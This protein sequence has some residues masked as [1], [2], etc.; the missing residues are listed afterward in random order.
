[1]STRFPDL[2]ILSREEVERSQTA[3]RLSQTEKYGGLFYLG[4]GGLAV[5][6][7][8]VSWFGWSVWSMR[9]VW[10][11]VYELTDPQRPENERIEAANRLASDP[12]A[13]PRQLW[14]LSLNRSVPPLARYT[15]AATLDER[16]LEPDATAYAL[17]IAR[18]EGWPDWLRLALVRPL[19][20][21]A[22]Q[23]PLPQAP[24][25]ELRAHPSL[26][27]QAWAAYAQAVSRKDEEAGKALSELATIPGPAGSVAQALVTALQAPAGSDE[28][29][30]AL[31]DATHQ[32]AKLPEV[33]TLGQSQVATTPT[34]SNANHTPETR[35][36]K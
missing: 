22:E 2:P 10:S 8:L 5:V 35:E 24:L 23:W 17:A 13:T 7:G 16:A 36:E 26:A 27:I 9:E 21:G 28:R 18:S 34:G 19:A 3:S 6:I 33:E 20:F 12:D 14:D 11:A 30:A 4:V 1:M 15:L 25:A 31:R 32:G 29:R